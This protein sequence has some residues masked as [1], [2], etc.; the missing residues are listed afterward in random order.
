MLMFM[1]WLK[2][3]QLK[4]GL[5]DDPS[6]KFTAYNSEDNEGERDL[7]K[8]FK[9]VMRRFPDET[10][11]FLHV[12]SNRGDSE[13]AALLKRVNNRDDGNSPITP[14]HPKDRDEIIP[15]ISDSGHASSDE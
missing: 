14:E 6:S 11:D 12:F 13:I 7:T 3:K 10:M 4:E 8:L 1:D 15:P 5:G 9:L 2:K